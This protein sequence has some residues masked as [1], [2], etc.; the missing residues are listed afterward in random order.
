MASIEEL[1]ASGLLTFGLVLGRVG[2]LVS[3]CPTFCPEPLRGTFKAGLVFF[4]AAALALSLPVGPRPPMFV[5]ALLAEICI[6]ACMGLVVRI[7]AAAITQV[8]DLVEMVVG[9][10]FSQIVDPMTQEQGGPLRMLAQTMGGM[11]FFVAGGQ[12]MMIDALARSFHVMPAGLTPWQPRAGLVLV[13]QL[14]QM[15]TLALRVAAPMLAAAMATLLSLAFLTKVAPQLNIWSIGF[16]ITT[17]VSLAGLMVYLPSW[18]D[19][20]AG[21]WHER[22]A[23]MLPT[24]L[25]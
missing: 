25:G 16:L 21:L 24:V 6:G 12:G 4:L 14:G 8:G 20:T 13:A 10:G 23:A 9:F 18:I 1:A 22:I 2:A 15:T 5:A 3:T 17:T 7:G 19:Q 11:I